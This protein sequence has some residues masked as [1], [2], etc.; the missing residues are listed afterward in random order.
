[1]RKNAARL[2]NPFGDTSALLAWDTR[3]APITKALIVISR[4]NMGTGTRSQHRTALRVLQGRLDRAYSLCDA[5]SFLL[6]REHAISEALTTDRHF[7]QEG[8]VRP[9][10]ALNAFTSTALRECHL[11]AGI[12]KV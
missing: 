4:V 7:E 8:F 12:D 11:V 5:V 10:G 9:A 6:M 2:T 3:P 1:V